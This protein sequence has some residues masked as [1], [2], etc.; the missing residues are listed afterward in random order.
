MDHL[1]KTV[2]LLG[3]FLYFPF[4]ELVTMRFVCDLCH[5]VIDGNPVITECNV[6]C[7]GCFV[8]IHN[9]EVPIAKPID[10]GFNYAP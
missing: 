3:G 5:N 10:R 1:L 7:V 6:F 9:S 2:L 4:F 8:T